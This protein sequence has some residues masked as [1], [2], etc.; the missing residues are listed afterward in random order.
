[1]NQ[2]HEQ[3]TPYTFYRAEVHSYGKYLYFTVDTNGRDKGKEGNYILELAMGREWTYSYRHLLAGRPTNGIAYHKAIQA[4]MVDEN[5]V[6]KGV[7]VW[8]YGPI[9]FE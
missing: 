1:M 6:E 8:D 5:G 7:G 3:V 4:V 9:V 2:T